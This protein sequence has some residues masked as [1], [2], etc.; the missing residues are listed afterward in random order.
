MGA[1]IL[2]A[3]LAFGCGG[4]AAGTDAG[5]VPDP[6]DDGAIDAPPPDP[7]RPPDPPQPPALAPCPSGWREATDPATGTTTCDPWPVTGYAECSAIDEA[8]FP[9]E[10]GCVRVGTACDPDD[11]WATDLP[12]DVTVRYVL[13]GAPAGGDGSRA[14]PFGTI[15]EATA[16][17]PAGTVV[18]LSKGAFDEEVPLYGGLTVWG[19][20]VAETLV[21]SS[22]PAASAGSVVLSG[23]NAE[24]R[25]LRVGGDRPGVWA[26][27]RAAS[28]TLR[29][30]VIDQATIFGLF[31]RDGAVVAGRGVVI[32][33][34]RSR[35]AD[36]RF[37]HGLHVE[38]AGQVSLSRVLLSRNRDVGAMATHTGSRLELEDAAVADTLSR[39][40]DL[41]NGM[42]IAVQ[43]AATL[44][45]RRLVLERNRDR[46]LAANLAGTSVLLDHVVIR[47]T[48]SVERD[49]SAGLGLAVVEGAEA[50]VTRALIERNR[51]TGIAVA[52][53]GARL[54]L[55]DVVV[56]DTA[57]W[58]REGT[59][60]RGI[61]GRDG[62]RL[63]VRRAVLE[64][65]RDVAVLV[66]GAGTDARLE[67]VAIRDTRGRE[68]DGGFGRGLAAQLGAHVTLARVLLDRNREIGIS[69]GDAEGRLDATDVEIRDTLPADGTAS[70]GVG[71]NTICG[72]HAEL[73][74]FLITG[75]ALCGIQ[76]A[77]GLELGTG[78][79]SE[80]GGTIDLHDGVVSRNAVCGANV[81]TAGF[82]LRRLQ[83]N[84]RWHDNGTDLDMAELPVPDPSRPGS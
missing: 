54:G 83:D 7:P 61:E 11:P 73:R 38:S 50:D 84:V 76:L 52:H 25:N 64:R 9:G 46:G 71:I 47:D 72:G 29:D 40:S 30:V 51:S 45:A 44:D 12:E 69:I 19:A 28:G 22:T 60:G 1:W 57:S 80:H 41:T 63:D 36:G 8:H 6:P 77:H 59:E 21:A 20:C 62:A 3:V 66:H 35:P 70:F 67:D 53:A 4:D 31:V 24:L 42:G 17:A 78:L 13:A 16:G 32:R 10:P 48:L 79:P 81:Q 65:N 58:E 27:G 49:R 33:R 74:A 68:S 18:A 26:A 15:R 43:D 56:R 5:E 37:G 55:A 14:S 82:D 23:R 39:Q 2:S 34:T 75:S